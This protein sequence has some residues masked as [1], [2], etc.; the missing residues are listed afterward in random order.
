MRRQ[1]A[2]VVKTSNAM[3]RIQKVQAFTPFQFTAL[4]WEVENIRATAKQLLDKGN[5]ALPAPTR[6]DR[7]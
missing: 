2:L 6:R 5:Q 7:R 3:L 1:F 4:G